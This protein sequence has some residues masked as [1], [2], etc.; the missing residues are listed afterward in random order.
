[1]ARDPD[2]Q[3]FASYPDRNARRRGRNGSRKNARRCRLQGLSC[4]HPAEGNAREAGKEPQRHGVYRNDPPPEQA[5]QQYAGLRDRLHRKGRGS[6]NTHRRG[7]SQGSYAQ[8]AAGLLHESGCLR[9]I[10]HLRGTHRAGP[11][12]RR[13]GKGGAH[14]SLRCGMLNHGTGPVLGLDRGCQ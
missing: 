6:E 13:G 4:S 5:A 2:F 3:P 7:K 10:P 12:D 11:C 9:R 14:R 1:M 8:K